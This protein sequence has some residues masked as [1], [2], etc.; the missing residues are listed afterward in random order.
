[1]RKGQIE[2]ENGD[3]KI[4]KERHVSVNMSNIQNLQIEKEKAEWTRKIEEEIEKDVE[5]NKENQMKRE[6][7]EKT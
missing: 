2:N 5:G 4:D 7:K 3:R 1:M 6:K